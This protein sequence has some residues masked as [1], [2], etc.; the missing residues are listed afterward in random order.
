MTGT[1]AGTA[2]YVLSRTAGENKDRVT[3]GGDYCLSGEEHRMLAEICGLYRRVVA[4]LNAGG[5]VDLSFLD[6][7]ANI[8]AVL[9]IVQPGMEGGSALADVLSGKVTPSG[10]LT[11]TWAYR[12]ADYPMSHSD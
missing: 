5:V 7:F 6:E 3:D 8:H 1:E 2:V 12:Y 10:K 4:I 9:C 11:D